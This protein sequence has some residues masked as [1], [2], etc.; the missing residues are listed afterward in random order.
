MPLLSVLDN[1]K[2]RL[3]DVYVKMSNI[4]ITIKVLSSKNKKLYKKLKK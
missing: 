1:I 3:K 4:K 2:Y